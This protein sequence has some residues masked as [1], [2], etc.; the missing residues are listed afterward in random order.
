MAD[1]TLKSKQ[2]V[3]LVQ[4]YHVTFPTTDMF[5]RVKTTLQKLAKL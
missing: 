3:E 1:V 2:Q 5:L 4:R